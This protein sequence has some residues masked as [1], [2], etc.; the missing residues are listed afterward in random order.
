MLYFVC[1]APVS[2]FQQFQPTYYNML[3]SIKLK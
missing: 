3:N 1:V 2:K